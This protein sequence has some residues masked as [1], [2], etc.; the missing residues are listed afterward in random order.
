MRKSAATAAVAKKV[1]S[2]IKSVKPLDREPLIALLPDHGDAV[3]HE[4]VYSM[5][6]W[7][8][9]PSQ[10]LNALKRL[11]DGV[12]DYNELRIC[13]ADEIAALLGPRYPMVEERAERLKAALHHIYNLEHEVTLAR[14]T[15]LS[16]RDARAYLEGLEGVPAF[17]VSRVLLVALGGHAAPVDQRLRDQ[18]VAAK[19]ADDSLDASTIASQL[20][21]NVRA[22]E[23]AE[24]FAKL[25]AWR[26]SAPTPK[27]PRSASAS[28]PL[29]PVSSTPPPPPPPK[30]AAST[31][32]PAREA[33]PKTASKKAT[34]KSASAKP[35]AKAS[36]KTAAPKST[37]KTPPKKAAKKV[38][39]KPSA[40]KAAKK[41]TKKA[42]KRTAKKKAA[43]RSKSA[44]RSRAAKSS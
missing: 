23:S 25:E 40:K 21:R 41:T 12:V 5:L 32:L 30:P 1:R 31:P 24:V 28:A 8:A 20:E 43:P 34:K 35:P 18:L 26:D 16:K 7:E 37:A 9:T 11:F 22:S 29:P 2:L 19:A 36:T 38:A 44:S 17:V 27:Q 14:L 42:A 10:A 15:A 39:H 33:A 4:L 3:V 6:I 13:M